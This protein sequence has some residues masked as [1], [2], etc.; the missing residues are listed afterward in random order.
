MNDWLF[1]S[2]DKA[3]FLSTTLEDIFPSPGYQRSP[4][5]SAKGRRVTFTEPLTISLPSLPSHTLLLSSLLEP[6]TAAASPVKS[7][8]NFL[9]AEASDDVPTNANT[10]TVSFASGACHSQKDVEPKTPPSQKSPVASTA[11]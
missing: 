4:P 8:E 3:A 5:P 10:F 2:I 9:P 11:V 6:Q 1:E 7:S